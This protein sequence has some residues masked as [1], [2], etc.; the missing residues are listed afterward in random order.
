MRWIYF[1]CITI[2]SHDVENGITVP[3]FDQ[4]KVESVLLSLDWL[5]EITSVCTA[6]RTMICN[7]FLND[8]FV[9]MIGKED[10][11]VPVTLLS[12][13]M[14]ILTTVTNTIQDKFG[15]MYSLSHIYVIIIM[16]ID[17]YYIAMMCTYIFRFLYFLV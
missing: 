3:I 11:F 8:A 15:G 9:K 5:L 6:Y 2:C 14:H 17:V 10:E 7:T 13:Y 12:Q 1:T 4:K 16:T